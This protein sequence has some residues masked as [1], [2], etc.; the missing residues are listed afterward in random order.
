MIRIEHVRE[1]SFRMNSILRK[2]DIRKRTEEYWDK[3]AKHR[4]YDCYLE[5]LLGRELEHADAHPIVDD[6]DEVA[7]LQRPKSNVHT[8]ALTVG[9]SFEPLLQII[10]VLQP[11]R[12]VLILNRSY[13]ETT[14]YDHGSSLCKLIERISDR[15]DSAFADFPEQFRPNVETCE[16]VEVK[17]DTPTEVFRALQAEMQKAEARPPENH[18][19]VVDITGA[20]KSMVV[21]AFLY[22]AHSHHP[23]TYV[24]FEEYDLDYGR[25]YGYKPKIGQISDPYEAFQLRDWE[26]VRQLY[27]RYNFRR[28]R[29]LLGTTA[30]DG[31]P[32]SGILKV[33]SSHLGEASTERSLYSQEDIA[34]AAQL[35]KLLQ[36]YEIW[37]NGDYQHAQMLAQKLTKEL[38]DTE[39]LE[40]LGLWPR[41]IFTLE[42]WPS[43]VKLEDKGEAVELDEAGDAALQLLQEHLALKRGETGPE[44]SIFNQPAKLFAYT[45]DEFAKIERLIEKNE[46]YRS[47]YLRSV[48]LHEFLLKARMA[49]VWLHKQV[50]L[51]KKIE[52]GTERIKPDALTEQNFC[53]GFDEIVE[54][55]EA[56]HMRNFLDQDK[57]WR[58]SFR[59]EG[60]KFSFRINQ[61]SQQLER[62]HP[63]PLE[64]Y[65]QGQALNL[66]QLMF[67]STSVFVKLRHEAI[68]THL[69]IPRNVAEA[70]CALVKSAVA[71]FEQNWLEHFYP[72]TTKAAG[73]MAGSPPLDPGAQAPEWSAL[74]RLLK[75]DFLPPQL[76]TN[77]SNTK[78]D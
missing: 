50:E 24:D 29:A 33:M 11:K 25:P 37:E 35:A 71:E 78:E 66:E 64:P 54:C 56:Q 3:C 28:A 12:V 19:N 17:A 4:N 7:R 76:R 21:G 38:S 67:G 63:P 47:A 65:W 62:K 75:L 53:D 5:E 44:T 73:A 41:A 13:A 15:T 43:A 36:V 51:R 8:L 16:Q 60:G 70:A 18:I 77:L 42:D 10:C 55:S 68:H 2:P 69:Y 45:R 14:G 58:F 46:D 57:R 6:S 22:A 72:G 74:C 40:R 27:D 48:G 52:H 49:Q 9:E 61:R 1:K 39:E 59:S 30:T 23:I 20:K 26:Q 34:K 31:N 32:A